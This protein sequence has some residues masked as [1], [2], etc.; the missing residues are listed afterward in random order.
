MSDPEDTPRYVPEAERG[1]K[2]IVGQ[3][4]PKG[5]TLDSGIGFAEL[6]STSEFPA[7]AAATSPWWPNTIPSLHRTPVGVDRRQARSDRVLL[8]RVRRELR[9]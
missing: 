6:F 8:R 5:D 9:R 2:S 1:I 4:I 3:P 7:I